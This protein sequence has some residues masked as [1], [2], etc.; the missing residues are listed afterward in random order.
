M[1]WIN[2]SS[3]K[4]LKERKDCLVYSSLRVWSLIGLAFIAGAL[5]FAFLQAMVDVPLMGEPEEIFYVAVSVMFVLG[6][7]LFSL[8]KRK[9]LIHKNGSVTIIKHFLFLPM[10]KEYTPDDV[11]GLAA[12]RRESSPNTYHDYH[13]EP[14]DVYWIE[15]ILSD[16]N[17]IR[18][19]Y[20]YN[21]ENLGD[22]RRKIERF[23]GIPVTHK[24]YGGIL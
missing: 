3:V 2:M 15:L 20:C 14:P 12:R 16:G 23:T 24:K 17:R 9:V 7:L 11:F 22:C 8:Y 13:H 5:A 10:R 1:L 4:Q 21:R 6:L 19:F 18:L